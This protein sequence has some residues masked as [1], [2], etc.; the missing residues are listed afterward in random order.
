[1][2]TIGLTCQ[3]ADAPAANKDCDLAVFYDSST[4]A[5]FNMSIPGPDSALA[6]HQQAAPG[7]ATGCDLA[8]VFNASSSNHNFAAQLRKDKDLSDMLDVASVLYVNGSR[9]CSLL[10]TAFSIKG[11][12]RRSQKV[13]CN[14]NQQIAVTIARVFTKYTMCNTVDH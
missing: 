3:K 1:M 9:H 11:M 8:A 5:H 7:T 4:Y 2:Q 13:N 14:G 10:F 6:C 12:T